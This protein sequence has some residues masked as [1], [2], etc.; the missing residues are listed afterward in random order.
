VVCFT[1]WVLL[2][3]VCFD[4]SAIVTTHAARRGL[5]VPSAALL[6]AATWVPYVPPEADTQPVPHRC[7][8][9]RGHCCVLRRVRHGCN[10]HAHGV[11]NHGCCIRDPHMCRSVR[12]HNMLIGG[13][14]RGAAPRRRYA[15]AARTDCKVIMCSR[16]GRIPGTHRRP[17]GGRGILR[18]L[19]LQG[20]IANLWNSPQLNTASARAGHACSIGGA[21]PA[22]ELERS[23]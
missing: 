1:S 14:A 18:G 8:S 23:S 2:H 9:R 10:T 11:P 5:V 3:E 22:V 21:C 4:E 16:P 20:T 12:T 7:A 15:D 6:R 19:P 13:I 17:T